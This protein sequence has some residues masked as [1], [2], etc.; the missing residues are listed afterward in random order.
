MDRISQ[1]SEN[2][3]RWVVDEYREICPHHSCAEITTLA[4]CVEGN[5]FLVYRALHDYDPGYMRHM[6]QKNTHVRTLRSTVSS[7]LV[8][9]RSRLKAF[10]DLAFSIAA[11][12]L[13]NALPRDITYRK[14][15][16]GF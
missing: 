11:P 16:G 2:C 6:L 1:A 7:Q 9:P 14:S 3:G 4:P 10:Q 8:V 13:R 5:R 12:R 15:G